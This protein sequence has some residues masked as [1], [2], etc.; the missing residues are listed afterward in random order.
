MKKKTFAAGGRRAYGEGGTL[1]RVLGGSDFPPRIPL[2]SSPP[3]PSNILQLPFPMAAKADKASAIYLERRTAA[4]C[5]SLTPPTLTPE[6]E[7]KVWRKI[8][9]RLIPILALLYLFCFLD[10]GISY[11][12][13]ASF[14]RVSHTVTQET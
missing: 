4:S 3:P 14:W 7:A 2:F 13:L 9:V 1:K 6:E 8:D 12:F 5:D 10:R 11:H